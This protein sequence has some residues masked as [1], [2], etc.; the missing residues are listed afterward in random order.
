MSEHD[1]HVSPDGRTIAL[2][3][4]LLGTGGSDT[5]AVDLI[6][7]G[8]GARRRLRTSIGR[9]YGISW[10]PNGRSIVFTDAPLGEDDDADVFVLHLESGKVRRLTEDTAW[11]HMPVWAPDGEHV[12]FTSYRSGEERMYSIDLDSGEIE[13]L[14][15]AG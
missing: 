7:L 11:D 6:D 13:R 15:P 8:S 12:L 2:A 5:S 14:R 9:M 1:A 3:V 4:E 10:S